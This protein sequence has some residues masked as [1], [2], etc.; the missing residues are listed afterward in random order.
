MVNLKM[1]QGKV[2]LE[3]SHLLSLEVL[4]RLAMVM[5]EVAKAVRNLITGTNSDQTVM[6]KVKPKGSTNNLE[7]V[8]NQRILN[9]LLLNQFQRLYSTS[10]SSRFHQRRVEAPLVVR[11]V[12]LLI[13]RLLELAATTITPEKI[14]DLR[15]KIF[16]VC[17]NSIQGKIKEKM[18]IPVWLSII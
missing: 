14:W 16:N 7:I 18:P 11:L 1:L 3:I 5:E 9:L 12:L 13:L 8:M 2:M 6:A 17:S 15:E 4:H 10:T